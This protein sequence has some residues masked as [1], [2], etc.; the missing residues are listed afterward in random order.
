MLKLDLILHRPVPKGKNKKG[1]ELMK[2]ELGGEIMT[3]FAGLRAK[4]Y[5][6]LI[7]DDSKD[8]KAKGPKKCVIKNAT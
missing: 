6:Y 2:D 8:K 4:M 5:S 1:I 7:D 3:E